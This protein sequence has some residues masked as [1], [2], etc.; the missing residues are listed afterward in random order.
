MAQTLVRVLVHLIFSTKDRA[1]VIR[2]DIESE[3]HAYL[4]GIA[5]NLDSPCLAVN[6]T[7]DHVHMLLAQSKKLALAKLLEEV[8]K[9]SSKWI[10]TKGAAFQ[11]FYWQDGYAAFSVSQSR[12]AAVEAYIAGQKEHHRKRTFQEE[13]IQ[14]LRKHGVEYDERYIW[15]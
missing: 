4:A 10:K 8:K 11:R 5:N 6:G 13:L 12:V 9:G 1:P 3:L 15:S 2:P 7:H 14:F